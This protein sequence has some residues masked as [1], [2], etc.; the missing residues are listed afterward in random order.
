MRL[1]LGKAWVV[2]AKKKKKTKTEMIL[3]PILLKHCPPTPTVNQGVGWDQGIPNSSYIK[4]HG[5]KSQN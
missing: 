3:V 4:P 1:T 5:S 2:A